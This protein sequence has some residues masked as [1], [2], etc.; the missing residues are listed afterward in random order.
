[1]LLTKPIT[2]APVGASFRWRLLDRG[3]SAP[4]LSRSVLS[5][6]DDTSFS[7]SLPAGKNEIKITPLKKISSYGK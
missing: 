2:S 7:L 1:M 4:G 6:R 5:S 3:Q